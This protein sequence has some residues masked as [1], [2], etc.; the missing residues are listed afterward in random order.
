[1]LVLA[2]RKTSMTKKKILLVLLVIVLF[3]TGIYFAFIRKDSSVNTSKSTGSSKA[4]DDINYDPPTDSDKEGNDQNKQAVEAQ[5]KIEQQATSSGIKTVKPTITYAS[6]YDTSIEVGSYVSGVFESSGTCK[7]TF[8]RNGATFTKS[9]Q[10]VQGSNSMSCPV[11]T[12]AS[13]E[14]NPKGT[15]TVS[16]NYS[17]GS[18]QGSSDSRQ[19]EV[20]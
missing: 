11:I 18:A 9:V 5:N 7:A 15:W 2:K 8:M 1:M 12:A 4:Q 10:A 13:S 19:L 16:V 3:A 6:Q 17:S 20:K 14:F